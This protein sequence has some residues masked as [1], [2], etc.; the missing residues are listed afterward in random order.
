MATTVTGLTLANEPNEDQTGVGVIVLSHLCYFSK[1]KQVLFF[2]KCK[3]A[4]I[5]YYSSKY[6]TVSNFCFKTLISVYFNF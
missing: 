4:L 1:C 2:P 5:L 6:E 3:Q